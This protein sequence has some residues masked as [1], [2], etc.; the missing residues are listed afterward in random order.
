MREDLR[1]CV[2][3]NENGGRDWSLRGRAL[4]RK[5]ASRFIRAIRPEIKR[6]LTCDTLSS[7]PSLYLSKSIDPKMWP[8]L[9][10]VNQTTRT[11]TSAYRATSKLK[12]AA[13]TEKIKCTKTLQNFAVNL[14]LTQGSCYKISPTSLLCRGGAGQAIPIR[15]TDGERSACPQ[16]GDLMFSVQGAL[17]NDSHSEMRVR[18]RNDLLKNKSKTEHQSQVAGTTCFTTFVGKQWSSSTTRKYIF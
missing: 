14:I 12:R 5:S 6:A 13:E 2:P 11:S 15:A 17:H 9:T 18:L 3:Q 7:V 4:E 8:Q 1:R 10:T 16:G